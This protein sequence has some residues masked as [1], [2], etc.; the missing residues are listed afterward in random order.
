MSVSRGG[1]NHTDTGYF[2]APRREMDLDGDGTLDVLVPL[3]GARSPPDACPEDVRWAIYVVRGACGHL[4]GEIEGDPRQGSIM[5]R[6]LFDIT[7]EIAPS[8][9]MEGRTSLRY[10]FDGLSYREGAREVSQPRCEQHPED[11]WDMPHR[12]CALRDHPRIVS[13]FDSDAA[14]LLLNAAAQHAQRQCL[15]D[16]AL[17]ER[18]D[19]RPSFR[20]DGRI[21][22]VR[23]SGC[24]SR[25]ECVA[26]LFEAI[27]LSPFVGEP[28]APSISFQIPAP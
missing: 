15:G 9:G 4:V 28:G 19:V 16:I 14:I 8:S 3:P 26:P 10:T 13:R 12:T 18:C 17:V 6:G 24:P 23:L 7:A 11:C 1:E 20:T 2:F 21:S 5:S 25:R 22:S 27:T